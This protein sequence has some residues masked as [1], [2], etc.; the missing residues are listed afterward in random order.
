MVTELQ[1]RYQRWKQFVIHDLWMMDLSDMPFFKR[2]ALNALKV[3]YIVVRGFVQDK[4]ALQA[5]A[6]TFITLMSIVPCLAL[7]LS[8][9]KGLHFDGQL[10][11]TILRYARSNFPEHIQLFIER[12]LEL[13]DQTSFVALGSLG[14]VF[15]LFTM[16]KVM[17]RVE[18][19]L[20]GIWGVREGRTWRRKFADYLSILFVVPFLILLATSINTTLASERVTDVLQQWMAHLLPKD[21]P[22]SIEIQ[23]NFHA[24]YAY[25]LLYGLLMRCVGVLGIIGALLFLYVFMPNT[26]VKFRSALIGAMSAGIM[27]ILWQRFCINFQFWV[28]R[29]N[30]IYGA[31]ASL[32]VALFW[33]DIN[34]V[35]ILFGAEISFAYQ[36]YDTYVLE[37]EAH[38]VSYA[39]RRR[40]AFRIVLE[41]CKA[42][43]T[44]GGPWRTE[45]FQMGRH[46]PFRLIQEMMH[47]LKSHG[48]LTDVADGGWVP[49]KDIEELTL[50]DVEMAVAGEL[51]GKFSHLGELP[52]ALVPIFAEQHQT[53]LEQLG[54]RN[55]HDL[56]ILVLADEKE[57]DAVVEQAVADGEALD[58][59]AARA[60]LPPAEEGV[61]SEPA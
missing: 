44:G 23:S 10:R 1:N 24:W 27:W 12:M 9:A 38:T 42:F 48:I 29:Y 39:L 36:N 37:Q 35:I 59:L 40:L 33:L 55:Y 6:L 16:I 19:T 54:S 5:S 18:I 28:T 53:Y 11:F 32:P 26:K 3:G 43:R 17:E 14:C 22:N 58:E 46:V 61:R 45:A 4:C 7:V 49:A 51:D 52:K 13:V 30:A 31:F 56:V 21:N 50:K 20:N 15:I 60:D 8:A 57:A 47:T 2:A 34:W 41:V 25:Y